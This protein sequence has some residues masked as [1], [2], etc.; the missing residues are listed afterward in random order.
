MFSL[1]QN[2]CTARKNTEIRDFLKNLRRHIE[3]F[4]FK[5]GREPFQ[6]WLEDVNL[7]FPMLCKTAL[8]SSGPSTN[9]SHKMHRDST[10]DEKMTLR[11]SG[12]LQGRQTSQKT[13]F[14]P[15]QP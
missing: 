2:L 1:K 14:D 13:P 6:R 5:N 12:E 11:K 7:L 4:S 10:P 8:T 9:N 3:L 15:K